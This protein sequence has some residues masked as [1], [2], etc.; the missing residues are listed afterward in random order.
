MLACSK[1][2][3]LTRPRAGCAVTAVCMSRYV[4]VQQD[5]GQDPRY[6][7]VGFGYD[8]SVLP[9]K[10]NMWGRYIH[11]SKRDLLTRV[12]RSLL[13]YT[14]TERRERHPPKATSGTHFQKSVSANSENFVVN[15]QHVGQAHIFKSQ[16][17]VTC[18]WGVWAQTHFQKSVSKT[19]TA[20]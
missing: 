7:G 4:Q 1:K 18:V 14:C 16:C 20:F 10:S 17:P 11:M 5:A 3:R 2:Q 12:C 8:D 19:V 13:L 15:M 9:A 6:V